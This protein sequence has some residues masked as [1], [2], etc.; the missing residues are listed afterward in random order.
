MSDPTNSSAWLEVGCG[1]AYSLGAGLPA[2]DDVEEA[3]AA[4]EDADLGSVDAA[5]EFA[6]RDQEEGAAG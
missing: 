6:F 5:Q 3:S 2:C 4:V 1:S